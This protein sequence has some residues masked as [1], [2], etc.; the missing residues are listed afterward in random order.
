MVLIINLLVIPKDKDNNYIDK[1]KN[2]YVKK[3]NCNNKKGKFKFKD[4]II[5]NSY[6][7]N[8]NYKN[9]DNYYNRNLAKKNK[10]HKILNSKINS[11]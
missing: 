4:K 8:K 11:Y 1:D 6:N 2:W 7:K 10:L 9:K 3:R 5:L